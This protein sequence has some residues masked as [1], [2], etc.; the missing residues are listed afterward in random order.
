MSLEDFPTVSRGHA[1]QV[2]EL[3]KEDLHIEPGATL[4]REVE[5]LIEDMLSAK[6]IL[7]RRLKGVLRPLTASQ[8]PF[9]SGR[10]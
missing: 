4:G 9:A 7:H 5:A 8:P 10:G 6:Q 3:A 1:I 2:L